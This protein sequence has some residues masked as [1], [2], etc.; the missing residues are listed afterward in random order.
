[1]PAGPAPMTAT[2]KGLSDTVNLPFLYAYSPAAM[3]GGNGVLNR[4]AQIDWLVYLQ[5]VSTG[6]LLTE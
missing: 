3:R 5:Q 4:Y 1:M 2:F 6:F